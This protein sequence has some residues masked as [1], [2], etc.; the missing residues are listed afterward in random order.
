MLSI[1]IIKLVF[2]GN[3]SVSFFLEAHLLT[4]ATALWDKISY[5]TRS[6]RL[7]D[8]S[9]T[10]VI[11]RCPPHETPLSIYD[12]RVYTATGALQNMFFQVQF[13]LFIGSVQLE[14][15]SCSKKLNGYLGTLNRS[16]SMA[17]FAVGKMEYNPHLKRAFCIQRGVQQ[18][19][20]WLQFREN[21][22]TF[23]LSGAMKDNSCPIS[24]SVPKLC[25]TRKPRSLTIAFFKLAVI[26]SSGI[27]KSTSELS[28]E[29]SQS[30]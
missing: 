13:P 3:C 22:S 26:L 15:Y 9:I 12:L 24:P 17:S 16:F 18:N 28:F 4:G 30:R 14:P 7:R 25:E 20:S 19:P 2:S 6:R 10:G 11:K 21:T 29:I 5:R 23:V 27:A 1:F 8:V